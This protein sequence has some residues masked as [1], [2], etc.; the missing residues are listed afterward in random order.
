[1]S[2]TKTFVA[3]AVLTWID[4]EKNKTLV[5]SLVVVDAISEQAAVYAAVQSVLE[6]HPGANMMMGRALLLE[7]R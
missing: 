7:D 5:H 3:S 1:M 2:H 6:T 4:P